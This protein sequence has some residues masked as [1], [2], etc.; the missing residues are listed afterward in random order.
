MKKMYS[1]KEDGIASTVGTIFALMIFTSLLSMF[2]MQVVPVQMKGNEAQHDLKVVSQ[3]SYMRSMMDLLTLTKNSNY[4]TYVPIKLGAEGI[5]L[6]ASPTYGQLSVFPATNNSSFQLS[7]N[8]ID[9]YGNKI[10]ANSSGSIQIL[11]P[12]RYYVAEMISYENGAVIR[13]NIDA[14]NASFVMEPNIKFQYSESEGGIIIS[15][16][17]QVIYGLPKSVTG[18]ETRNLGITYVGSSSS[19]YIPKNQV[20]I[21][22]RSNYTYGHLVLNFTKSWLDYLNR[23]ITAAILGIPDSSVSVSESTAGTL[24]I[25]GVVRVNIETVYFEVEI[26]T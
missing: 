1:R 3:F 12:N 23:S 7:L 17:L 5:T 4:T 19:S 10:Y 18:M 20:N 16:V 14:K 13:Y 8:F 2:M 9:F 25:K 15:A 24:N 22:V 11:L 6:F 26:G 21:T